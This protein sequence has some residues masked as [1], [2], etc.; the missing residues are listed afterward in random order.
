VRIPGVFNYFCG[1]AFA[2]T[3]FIPQI[4]ALSPNYSNLVTLL[5]DRA[6][7]QPQ[8]IAYT[9]L[10]DGESDEVHLTYAELDR[11]SRAIAS[12]LQATLPH[13]LGERALLLYPPGLDYIKAFFGCLYAGVI[14][15]PAYPPRHARRANRLHAIATDAQ[16]AII[17]GKHPKFRLD[18]GIEWLD[19]DE[20]EAENCQIPKIDPESTAFLQYTSGSTGKPKGVEVTHANLLHNLGAIARGM[21]TSATDVGVIWLPPYHDMGL[22]GGLLQ[23]LYKGFRCIGMSPVAFLQQ[24]YRWLRAIS[25]YG[26]TISGAPNFAYHLCVERISDAQ[27]QTLDLSRWRIAFTGAEPIRAQTLQEFSKAFAGCGF[28]DRAFYPCYG[29]AESTLMVAGRKDFWRVEHFQKEALAQNRVIAS[30]TADAQPLVSCGQPDRD[31]QVAI[32]HPQTLQPLSDGEIGEVW[33]SSPSVAK[34]YWQQPQATKETFRAF[35]GSDLPFLRTGDLGFLRNGELYITGRLKDLIIIRGRNYYPQDIEQ[36]VE[37]AHPALQAGSGAVFSINLDDSEGLV[38]VQELKRTERKTP[39]EPIIKAIRDRVA[40]VHDLQA[41]AIAL[42]SP[43]RIPK[44]SSGKIQRRACRDSFL[45]HTLDVVGEWRI[46]RQSTTNNQQLTT[47][48]Q[49][50]TTN[51]QQPTTNNQQQIQT[52][53]INQ[54]AQTLHLDPQTIDIH[55]P[56]ASYGLDSVTA[57]G[58][59]GKLETWLQRRIEPTLV[60]NYPTIAEIATYLSK[61]APQQTPTTRKTAKQGDIAIIGLGCRFPGAPNP[62][63]FW[64]LLAEGKEAIGASWRCDPEGIRFAVRV[65]LAYGGFLPRVDE[66]DAQFF[67]ISPRE[68]AEIDPQHRLLLEVM[69]EAL[70]YGGIAPTGLAGSQTG[71]FVGISSNDYAL[72]RS[73]ATAYTGLGNAHSIA[74]NRISYHLDLRGPCLAV[75]TACSSSLVAVHLA[76]QSLRQN[77]CDL[78]LVGG[79]NLILAEK[80]NQSLTQAQMLAPDGRCKTFA[81]AAD[82]YGRGEGCGVVVLKGLQDAIASND[83]ILAVIKGSAIAQDGRSNGITAPNGRSQQAAI[84]QA[85][86]NAG[87]SPQ[88]A[89]YIEAHGTGTPLGDPIEIGALQAICGGRE[90]DFPC[91]VASVKTNIGHLEAAAGIA[92]LIKVV[93][94]LQ[95]QAIPPHL[96]SKPLNPHLQL[97]TNAIAIPTQLQ[98]WPTGKMPRYAGVSSFGFGGTNAHLVVASHSSVQPE[99]KP[100]P[101]QS[102]HLLTLSA[103]HPQ[104]LQELTRHYA[105]WLAEQPQLDIADI[106]FTANTG[107]SHFNYRFAAVSE[108]LAQLEQQLRKF[109]PAEVV[110]G[111]PKI[112]FLCTGQGAQYLNAGRQLYD[113]QPQFRQ[114][115][116]ECDRVLRSE[117][118]VPLLTLLY[119]DDSQAEEM[120]ALLQQTQYAQPALFALECAIARVWQF[121]GIVPDIVIGHSLGEYVAAYLAG[122]F[123][124]TEGLRLVAARGRLMQTLPPGEMYAI[125]ASEDVVREILTEKVEIAAINA[126]DSIT[127]TGAAEDL[128]PILNILRDRGIQSRQL[129]V[130]SAFHS[131]ATESI[132]TEFDQILAN[133]TFRPLQRPLIA[134]LTGTVRPIGDLLDAKYW[135]RHLRE[136]VQFADGMKALEAWGVE[137]VI[138]VGPQPTLLG[139]S[140]SFNCGMALPSLR[141]GQVDWSV[142]LNSLAQLYRGGATIDWLSFAASDARDRVELPTYAFTRSRYWLET[143]QSTLDLI[144]KPLFERIEVIAKSCN[145]SQYLAFLDTLEQPTIFYILK[146]FEELGYNLQQSASFSWETITKEWGIL[147]KHHRF[148]YRLL[149]ILEKANI[150]RK[151]DQEWHVCQDINLENF[152]SLTAFPEAETEL[153]LLQRCGSNLAAIL[154][155]K[156]DP[157]TLLF[158]QGDLS[159]LTGLY[160]E[161]PGAKVMNQLLQEAVSLALENLPPKSPFKILEIGAGTGG[162][163]AGLLSQLPTE[164]IEYTFSDLSALFLLKAQEKFKD[165]DCLNYAKLNIEKSPEE[166]GFSQEYD[167]II[168]ANVLHATQDLKQTLKHIQ[169]LLVPQGLLIL[170]EGT[171]AISW[172]DLIFGVTEGWW[173]FTDHDLRPH[174]P[175]ISALQWQQILKE[176]GFEQTAKIAP[177]FDSIISPQTLIIAQ[178]TQQN[179]VTY[180]TPQKLTPVNSKPQKRQLQPIF[181]PNLIEQWQTASDPISVLKIYLCREIAQKLELPSTEIFASQPNLLDLGMDSLM[182]IE[183]KNS[184]EKTLALEL[185]PTLALEYPTLD[186]LIEYLNQKLIDK[187]LTSEYQPSPPISPQPSTAN[188]DDLSETQVTHLLQQLLKQTQSPNHD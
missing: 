70:E 99:I 97:D 109:T 86:A 119:P 173:R 27:K 103:K 106:C 107:R 87:I 3:V 63:Q 35:L 76:C 150:L 142:L 129:R 185:S 55:Q 12:R 113:T 51:N 151:E 73:P 6:W 50:L 187:Y 37:Q 143:P 49:Q 110:S 18:L 171:T 60:Y 165:Y 115:L 66:F 92:G 162:T 68:A 98:P 156:C 41:T 75:D 122:A 23:P 22:I 67:G 39:P 4:P 34:G 112:A 42:V 85:W 46:G 57:V 20:N 126:P 177:Q 84:A 64:Q 184:L 32:A 30:D 152:P 136:T 88:Q 131:G 81:A 17:L 21:E 120:A 69:W 182:A 44:T 29:L 179:A 102:H 157:L 188:L 45:N 135:C 95:Q 36:T 132:L 130:S 100:N 174:H 146:A 123:S 24:P 19:Y 140:Q 139:L 169:Q 62:R 91:A 125:F 74:A 116:A 10:N 15:I 181:N 53:L 38:V 134:N 118:D 89:S 159:L 166:Q 31:C 168:A 2:M 114:V 33:L 127:I 54:L 180:S 148:L 121:W 183:L 104:A 175:L 141:R 5:R 79:V 117:L 28:R 59:S 52:W 138:E 105:Q 16:P 48:N 72:M 65:G 82:G 160:Q 158:P 178:K 9:F 94:S 149:D 13:P 83:R 80:L 176:T 133:I 93:L 145:L 101:T 124:L 154:Q 8:A 61:K 186:S 163:T 90:R 128:I 56:L 96:Q 147:P 40:Q 170:L 167:I 108:D 1:A 47:N 172:L 25:C 71:V 144:R 11:C 153:T 43:G 26:G 58:L 77:E 161:S 7:C 111:S 14:A 164:K 155:G 137:A 78:A